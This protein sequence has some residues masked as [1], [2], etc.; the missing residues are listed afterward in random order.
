MRRFTN[1]GQNYTVSNI[2]HMPFKPFP[3]KITII[4]PA[5]FL[6]LSGFQLKS[7]N[8][9]LYDKGLQY[10]AEYK[11]TEG[12]AL[13]QLLLKSDSSNADYLSNAAYFF[14]KVG[15]LQAT[16]GRR[17][18]YFNKGVY[19]AKKAIKINPSS[20][21]AHY[22]YALGLGRLNENAGSKQKIA[23]ARLIKQEADLA[24]KLN[25]QLAG[26]YHI[27][28][29]WHRT[30]AGFNFV[31]KMAINTLFGGVPEGGSYES[32]ITS[33]QKAIQF[34]P[35]YMLHYYELAQTYSDRNKNGD[36]EQAR[37]VL[38]KAMAL[39]VKNE[40]DKITLQKCG[41]LMRKN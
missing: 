1:A 36:K 32:A 31:E 39:P 28:G 6:L 11:N 8:K 33:F 29:R 40:D 41:E 14:S 37:I 26:A 38:K 25:P 30:I 23:N 34:E 10:K 2:L 21:E 13:F 16:E 20:A 17:S 15:N 24:L 3:M 18:E 7:Q 19:L 9:Q 4:L 22:A 35:G 5:L 12:L 27:L